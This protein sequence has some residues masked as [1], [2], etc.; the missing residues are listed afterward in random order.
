MAGGGAGAIRVRPSPG[1][2]PRE[3][4]CLSCAARGMTYRE[5][6]KVLDIS[7]RTVEQHLASARS[8]LGAHSTAHA[9]AVAARRRII[10]PIPTLA[11]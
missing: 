6:A 1:L 5:I 11:E 10:T 9:I 8:K 3:R 7:P 2:T 4:D